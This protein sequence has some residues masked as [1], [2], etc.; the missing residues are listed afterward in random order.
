MLIILK[1]YLYKFWR[2]QNKKDKQENKKS[3]CRRKDNDKHNN[4]YHV[5]WVL[6]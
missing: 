4:L 5:P 2:K 3:M 1:A 6:S